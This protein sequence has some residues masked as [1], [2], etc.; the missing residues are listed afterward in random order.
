VISTAQ[1][2]VSL[3]LGSVL[4]ALSMAA[5]G[6]FSFYERKVAAWMQGRYGPNRV[7]PKGYFQFL[8]DGIKFIMK[9]DL[10]PDHVEKPIYLL[11]PAFILIPALILYAGLPIGKPFMWNGGEIHLQIVQA[12]VGILYLLAVAS[13][14]VYGLVLGAWASN[15]KY[16]LFGGVR[17]S[18]Q[19]ISYE[20]ALGL[21][22]ISVVLMSGDGGANALQVQQIVSS[23]GGYWHGVIPKWNAFAN[24]L[25]FVIF[26][27]CIYAETNR[28]PFDM[29]EAE[30]ELVGGYHTE[31]SAMKFAVFM[32]SE[33][34]NMITMSMFLVTLFFGGWQF[35]GIEAV[36]Y[37]PLQVLL[38]IGAFGLK[39][40]F[41]CFLFLWV[42]W[43]LPRFRYD[44]LMGLGWKVLLPIALATC[45]GTALV[46][47][48][49]M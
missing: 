26:L 48:W 15:S 5:A 41:F 17:A 36:S 35:P 4:I 23:Q 24:P 27:I 49:R 16:P 25:A 19:M 18:A 6:L 28:L 32:L 20:L 1:L 29:A 8:A 10:V 2:F 30:Q 22:I 11:A 9:E 13:L 37:E 34:V 40:L 42:R 43:T 47:A 33:Y 7:G 14:G 3:A 12:N 45:I 46:I 39:V 44:Q 21:S 38:S 31:Y